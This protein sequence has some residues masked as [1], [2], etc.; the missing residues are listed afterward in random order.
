[1]TT[2]TRSILAGPLLALGFGLA[3]SAQAQ[4]HRCGDS[5]LYTDKPCESAKPV[6]L[7]SNILNA[8][9]RGMPAAPTPAPAVIPPDPKAGQ[10]DTSSGTVWD[11][12]DAADADF[13]NRTGP[14]R[15]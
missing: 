14:Y 9:P 6:D 11:R 15:P 8:G 3:C 7:R 1:M 5:R 10:S 12:R 4:V 2:L 13:R